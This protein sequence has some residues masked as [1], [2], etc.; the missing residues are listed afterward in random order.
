MASSAAHG[1]CRGARVTA[2]HGIFLAIHGSFGVTSCVIFAASSGVAGPARLTIEAG[3]DGAAFSV[4]GNAVDAALDLAFIA[5]RVL[6]C[7]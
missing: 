1:A 3:A 6:S 5:V 4:C 2:E 7:L